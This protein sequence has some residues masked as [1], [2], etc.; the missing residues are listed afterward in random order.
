MAEPPGGTATPGSDAP[1]PDA[2]A[3]TAGAEDTGA[4][5]P[6][7]A[8]GLRRHAGALR[9]VLVSLALVAGL[10][11]FVFPTRA[12]LAQRAEVDR[13]RERLALLRAENERIERETARLSDPAEIERI[14]RER[15]GLVLPGERAFAV[16]PVPP[17]TTTTP[18]PGTP[19]PTAPPRR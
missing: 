12:F 3:G 8:D 17:S 10:F 19:T 16:V 14:A 5:G 1:G 15:F 11:A 6:P 18:P 4:A 7:R 13:A 2:P 9:V